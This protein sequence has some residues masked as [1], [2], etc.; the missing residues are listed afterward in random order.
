MGALYKDGP[1]EL[2]TL[3]PEG[4]EKLTTCPKCGAKMNAFAI[5]AY[6]I[7]VLV[8]EVRIV[9]DDEPDWTGRVTNTIAVEE[10]DY[11]VQDSDIS[12]MERAD[13]HGCED[14]LKLEC[15]NCGFNVTPLEGSY[16]GELYSKDLIPLWYAKK[17]KT[18]APSQS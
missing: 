8:N 2:K 15:P 16:D 10:Y 5:Q 17:L 9:L 1:D 13:C 18:K 11:T 3:T 6:R 12:K 14:S 4:L 7:P